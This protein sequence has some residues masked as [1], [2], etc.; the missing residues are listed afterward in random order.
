MMRSKKGHDYTPCHGIAGKFQK[1]CAL[2]KFVAQVTQINLRG[3]V[4][5]GQVLYFKFSL[6]IHSYMH[7]FHLV[8]FCS[9]FTTCGKAIVSWENFKY[10]CYT[11][12]LPRYANIVQVSSLH[13]LY[14][15]HFLH[16][17][18]LLCVRCAS[19]EFSF[20]TVQKP[21]IPL[22]MIV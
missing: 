15:C 20:I 18:L 8:Y 22:F 17:I 1:M 12:D 9:P 5:F 10:L 13:K 2:L 14:Y 21:L 16:K 19:F 7:T 6:L 4:I 3:L 11:N